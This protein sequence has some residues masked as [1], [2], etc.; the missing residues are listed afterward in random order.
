MA[1]VAAGNK[2]LGKEAD[3][4][5]VV[6]EDSRQLWVLLN[7]IQEHRIPA[8]KL[9]PFLK[10]HNEFAF[11]SVFE[12]TMLSE[13]MGQDIL[14]EETVLEGIVGATT[15]PNENIR[16]Y[17]IRILGNLVASKDEAMGVISKYPLLDCLHANLSCSNG[18]VRKDTCWLISNLCTKKATAT[19]VLQHGPLIG[20]LVELLA[21]EILLPLKRELTY[22]FCYLCHYGD[23]KEA[24][25]L[26]GHPNVIEICYGQLCGEEGE[27]EVVTL[28]LLRELI[29]L[30]DNF[31]LS[32][33]RNRMLEMM[34]GAGGLWAEIEKKS[35][36]ENAEVSSIS[37]EIIG[38]L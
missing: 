29:E 6:E 3:I 37:L 28:L 1:I 26:L 4:C 20:K 22:I 14:E 9:F 12:L 11:K 36:S 38:E 27:L 2:I 34:R 33:G 23:R 18:D 24:I 30:G 21:Y 35:Y 5:R 31:R 10:Q 15:H 17:A 16:K 25:N 7:H 8:T 32:E 13:A 19:Q